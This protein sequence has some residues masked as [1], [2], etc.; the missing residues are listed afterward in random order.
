MARGR[1]KRKRGGPPELE[2]K[3]TETV[4]SL[5]NGTKEEAAAEL[6]DGLERRIEALRERGETEN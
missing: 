1:R 4:S 6:A 2:R 3:P 5:S